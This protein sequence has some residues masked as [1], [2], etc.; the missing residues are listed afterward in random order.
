MGNPCDLKYPTIDKLACKIYEMS[1]AENAE[2]IL[3]FKEDLDRA[4]RQLSCDP[5][6]TPLLGYRWRG[7]CFFDIG[8]VM[9]CRISPYFCQRCT[10][11]IVY[12]FQ[13]MNHFM[14]NYVNDFIRVEYRSKAVTAHESFVRLLR[15]L[16]FDRSEKKLTPPAQII[17]FVGNLVDTENMTIGVTQKRKIEVLKELEEWRTRKMC[18]QRQLE[19][20]IRKLQF[21]SNCVR[22]GR[23]FVSR[24]LAEMK[25]MKQNKMYMV[26]EQMRKDIK[27]WYLFLPDFKGTSVLWLIDKITI[28]EELAVDSCLTSAGGVCGNNYYRIMY[29]K[30]FLESEKY[31]IAHLE[32]WVVIIAVK[33]WDPQLSGKILKIYSDNEAVSQIINSGRSQDLLLQKLLRELTWWLARHEFKVKSVHLR[34]V[35]NRIPDILSRWNE[36][37]QMQEEF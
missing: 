6:S 32:L 5:S 3:L 29:P 2:P 35:L 26:N 7:Y 30:W 28:D 18:N 24:L 15:D 17:E 22:P 8:T 27:W 9:G 10:S 19:S 20:L 13:N 33:L 16:G 31:Q 23:L 1:S 14:L 34:G 21:M 12:I 37:A 11:M 25:G 36:N 4:F